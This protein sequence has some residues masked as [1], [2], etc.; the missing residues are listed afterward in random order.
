MLTHC[1]SRRATEKSMCHSVKPSGFS[2]RGVYPRKSSYSA[3]P[4]PRIRDRSRN[5]ASGGV[6]TKANCVSVLSNID[7]LVKTDRL[8]KHDT[9]GHINKHDPH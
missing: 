3:A 6:S 2:R 1:R 9:L 4:F 7:E 5:K 8:M